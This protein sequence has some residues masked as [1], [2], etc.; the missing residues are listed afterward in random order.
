MPDLLVICPTRGRRQQ[1]ER[2]LKSFTGT[3]K[4][5]TTDLVFITDGDDDSYE[6]MDWGEANSGVLTPRDSLTGKLNRTADA[7]T[8]MYDAMMFVGD[9]HVFETDGWDDIMLHMLADMGGT[10]MI[11]PD[12]KRRT[13]VPEMIMI[14]SDIVKTLGC[15]AEPSL[16]HYYIDNAW[17]EIGKRTGLL[18]FCPEVVV[19]HLHY[20]VIG[21]GVERD[22]T[23]IEAENAW[24]ASDMQAYQTWLTNKMPVQVSQL[25]RKFNPDISWLLGRV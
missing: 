20:S 2:L 19:R 13:D 21:L 4:L 6:S 18:K 14:S 17:S 11:Y 23:Y 7:Y 10:G 9:D 16:K 15:F 3:K 22:Q 25:R 8:D 12:D 1:A 5:D 24:G